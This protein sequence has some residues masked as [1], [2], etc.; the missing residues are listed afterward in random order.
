MIHVYQA[1]WGVFKTEDTFVTVE[2]NGEL[3]VTTFPLLFLFFCFC[4][5]FCF[6]FFETAFLCVA[7]AVLELTL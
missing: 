6:F 5:C 2:A 3:L 7:L 4:F 1:E